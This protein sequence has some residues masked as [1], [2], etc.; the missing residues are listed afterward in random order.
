MPH[1]GDAIAEAI[2]EYRHAAPARARLFGNDRVH[3]GERRRE[4]LFANDVLACTQGRHDHRVVQRRRSADDH[5]VD[6]GHREHRLVVGDLAG[7]LVTLRERV[8]PLH[9]DVAAGQ[10]AEAIGQMSKA[11]GDVPVRNPATTD[12]CGIQHE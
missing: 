11:V 4:R 5:D 2:V 6:I 3:L 12:D 1:A 7:R 10:E 9:V 8:Q